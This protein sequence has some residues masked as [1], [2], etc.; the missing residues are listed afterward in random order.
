VAGIATRFE[1]R[2]AIYRAGEV[3]VALVIKLGG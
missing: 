3:T 1:K 2:A